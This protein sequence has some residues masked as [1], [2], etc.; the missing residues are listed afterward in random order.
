MTIVHNEQ[1]QRFELEKD[2]VVAFLDYKIVNQNTLDYQHT[3][4]PEQLS[5]QGIGSQLVAFALQYAQQQKFKVIASC[6]FV[7]RYIE[8]HPEYAELKV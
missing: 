1:T 7:A 2:G 5:G 8:K 3:I 4:V 6:S